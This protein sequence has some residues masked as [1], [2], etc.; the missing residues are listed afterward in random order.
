MSDINISSD[1]YEIEE[2]TGIAIP[3]EEERTITDGT[4]DESLYGKNKP[5][6]ETIRVKVV[7]DQ[8]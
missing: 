4:I 1:G 7:H 2:S 6:R 8:G 3:E 5:R